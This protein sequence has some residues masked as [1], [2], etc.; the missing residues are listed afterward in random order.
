MTN[1]REYEGSELE[2]FKNASSWKSYFADKL[3]VYIHGSV[4]EVG[5]GMGANTQFLMNSSVNEW[6]CVEPDSKLCEAILNSSISNLSSIKIHNGF[7]KSL[8]SA[9]YDCMIYIDVLEHIEDDMNEIMI[10]W[11][12]LKI[13]GY[14][15]TLSP[16]FQYF[17]SNFDQV[18]GHYR[19]Y[20]KSSLASIVP[21]E[22]F[23]QRELY[24]L[25][26]MGV[27][28]SLANKWFLKQEIPT[29]EQVQMWDTKIVPMSRIFDKLLHPFFGKSIVGV[30]QKR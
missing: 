20:N 6:T 25:D 28:A 18:I 13:N 5:A 19:R 30:W 11:D 1:H 24:Y 23:D 21:R 27:F 26:S 16:A 3:S 29:I 14:L 17:Y 2:L 12:K 10:A 9:Q 15:V 8:T 4:A 7:S 22:R